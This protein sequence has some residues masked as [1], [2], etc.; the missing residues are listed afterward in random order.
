MDMNNSPKHVCLT[1]PPSALSM[2]D[3]EDEDD[4]LSVIAVTP[5]KCEPS[6]I[7]TLTSGGNTEDTDTH[8]TRR[9]TSASSSSSFSVSR[10]TNSGGVNSLSGRGRKGSMGSSMGSLLRN[11]TRG[12]SRQGTKQ[13]RQVEQSPI[14]VVESR[15]S[16][17]MKGKLEDG[18][19]EEEERRMLKKAVFASIDGADAREFQEFLDEHGMERQRLPVLCLAEYGEEGSHASDIWVLMH[20]TV[21]REL[22]DVFEILEVIRGE[23]LGMRV[24]DVYN[25]RKWW[26]F[27]AVMWGEFWIHEQERIL[28]LVMQICLVDG[29]GDA[30]RRQVKKLRETREWLQLKMEELTSYVEEFETLRPGRALCLICK[31]IDSFAEKA[32]EYFA[33]IER[34]LPGVVDGYHGEEIRCEIDGAL[35]RRIRGKSYFAEM[36]VGMTRW[37]GTQCG[38]K[39]RE[40]W[41]GAHLFWVERQ[42]MERFEKRYEESHGRVLSYFRNRLHNSDSL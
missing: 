27:F 34:L 19:T 38:E 8:H 3:D 14:S 26:R 4:G 40:R 25:L 13:G 24:E 1:L 32:V 20:N 15:L 35:V 11:L 42:G 6:S 2:D 9:L 17:R 21:R 36:I 29:R 10:S 28:P 7:H 16:V 37:M 41:M 5:P 30:L 23:F 12:W 39:A 31:N 22:F 18:V 33:G